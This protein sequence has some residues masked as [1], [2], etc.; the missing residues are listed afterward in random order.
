MEDRKLMLACRSICAELPMV[1]WE[2]AAPRPGHPSVL[3]LQHQAFSNTNLDLKKR[4]CFESISVQVSPN[5]NMRDREIEPF[6]PFYVNT[7]KKHGC[8]LDCK[9]LESG[10]W[11]HQGPHSS[12]SC[13]PGFQKFRGLENKTLTVKPPRFKP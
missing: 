7:V 11:K 1:A 2:S 3:L 8:S 5:F 10:V 13:S 6:V 4:D 9:C 12:L